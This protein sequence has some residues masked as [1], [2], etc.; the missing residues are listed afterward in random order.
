MKPSDL[1]GVFI[2]TI[3]FLITLYGLWEIWGGMEN[4]VTNLLPSDNGDQASSFSY[5][6]DGIPSVIVGILIFFLAHWI[7]RLAYG[8]ADS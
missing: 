8:K 7:V 6:A 3:G 4:V 1:F 5:F 2:R